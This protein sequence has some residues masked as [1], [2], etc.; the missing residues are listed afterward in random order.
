MKEIELDAKI[1]N[2]FKV[3]AFVEE[4]AQLSGCPMEAITQL[5]IVVDEIF[6]NIAKYA[7]PD[8]AGK[9]KVLVEKTENP[10]CIRLTFID[11][12]IQYDPLAKAD[13][14]ITLPEQERQIG[15]LGI[16]MVKKTMD[17][18][19]YTHENGQNILVLEK[20]F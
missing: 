16:F 3:T 19:K 11:W 7:Y 20:C 13:P 5:N 8:G 17:S 6:S 4:F 1:A 14:D 2:L 10:K 15:G 12:G 18:M 9:V